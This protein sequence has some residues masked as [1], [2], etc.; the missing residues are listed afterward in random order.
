MLSV[1]ARLKKEKKKSAVKFDSRVNE[2]TKYFFKHKIESFTPC[3]V[4]G[5]TLLMSLSLCCLYL[6]HFKISWA[7]SEI[8]CII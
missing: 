3:S 8:A 4:I 7:G 1:L 6:E 5:F 2:T